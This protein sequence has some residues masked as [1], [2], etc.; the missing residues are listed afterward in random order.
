MSSLD[1]RVSKIENCESLHI[2]EFE[3]YGQTLSM[4]SLDLS[5]NVRVGTKVKLIVK[6]THIS[7][8]KNFSGDI[9]SSNR[10][11]TIIDS[12]ENGELLSSIKLRFADTLLESIITCKSSKEM[13]LQVG[14]SVVALIQS[15]ELS[16]GEIY[17][18]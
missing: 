2:V 11:N 6:S 9:S 10:L 8:A 16:I 13:N 12:C 1:A 7:I 14:D 15:S 5:A 18:V 4:M 3:C 17:D